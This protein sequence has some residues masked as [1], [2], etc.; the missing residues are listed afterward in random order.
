M[1]KAMVAVITRPSSRRNR[2]WCRR[3]TSAGQARVVGQGLEAVLDQEG[4]GLL[5]PAPRQAVDDARL[6]G[7]LG[8]QEAQE[9]LVRLPLGRHVVADVRPVEAGDE[10]AARFQA[11]LLADL[12]ARALVGGRGAGQARHRRVAVGQ[13]VELQVLRPEIVSPARDAVGLVDRQQGQAAR[14]LPRR[15]PRPSRASVRSCRSRSGAT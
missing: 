15:G 14:R 9:L 7:V 11:Q 1:P 3:R 8:L 10:D 2:S 13:D 4:G 5:H 6:P 12:A